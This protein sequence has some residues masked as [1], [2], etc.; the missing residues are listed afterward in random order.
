MHFLS[1]GSRE[2][3]GSVLLTVPAVATDDGGRERGGGEDQKPYPQ[4]S[5]L[6]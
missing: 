6:D 1:Q 2:K 3:D 4:N 5:R